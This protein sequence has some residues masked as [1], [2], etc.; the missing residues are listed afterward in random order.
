[1]LSLFLLSVRTLIGPIYS[2]G[3]LSVEDIVLR[4]Q[5]AVLKR[6]HTRPTFC[7]LDRLFWIVLRRFRSEWKQARIVVTPET[8]VRWHR[9]EFGWSW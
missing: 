8:A 4:Q 6:R 1:M 3:N 2:G 9:A 7:V 5:L